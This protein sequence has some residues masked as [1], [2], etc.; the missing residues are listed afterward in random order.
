MKIPLTCLKRFQ[1]FTET[2]ALENPWFINSK[3]FSRKVDNNRLKTTFVWND[4][5]KPLLQ[6]LWN[7]LKNFGEY[8]FDEI[9]AC[10]NS[11]KSSITSLNIV[12]IASKMSKSTW[13]QVFSRESSV[14]VSFKLLKGKQR[15]NLKKI[16]SY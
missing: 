15:W 9:A 4:P 10:R 2:F 3:I 8:P 1:Q 5:L 12:W 11:F 14:H 6:K 7:K 13:N 16:S